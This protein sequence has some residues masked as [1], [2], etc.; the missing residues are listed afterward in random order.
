M[1]PHPQKLTYTHRA[2]PLRTPA[3]NTAA[4]DMIVAEIADGDSRG[5]AEAVPMARYGETLAQVTATLDG[6]KGR[7]SGGLNRETLQQALPPG[8]ARNALDCAFWAIEADRAYC[9][10]ADLAGLE[11]MRPVTTAFTIGFDTAAKMAEQAAAERQRPLL[12]LELGGEGDMDRLHAVR[13]AAPAARL[14]ADAQARW[15]AAR[16]RDYLPILAECR[17]ELLSQPL[18][19]AEDAALTGLATPIPIWA[20]ES[21][22]S[23]ADLPALEGKYA[24]VSISLDKVGGL[25]EALSI[26]K[27]AR[28]SGL[29][30]MIDGGI[31]TSLGVA[32]A[33]LLAPLADVV[34]LD[35]PT[36]LAGDRASGLRYDGNTIQPPESKLW[37][38]HF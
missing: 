13:Q 5:R 10:V 31:T 21:C 15:D 11:P 9:S 12:K 36:R 17:I 27:H 14:I 7:V 37:G 23:T 25:T 22:R 30:I 28:N 20:D 2:W 29:R 35:G 38:G 8:A 6:L 16:L 1:A 24:G 32:Q 3:G 4:I 26:V 18:P 19:A 33:L 34:V